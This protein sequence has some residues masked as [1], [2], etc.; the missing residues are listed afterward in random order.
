MR[1]MATIDLGRCSGCLGCVEIAPEV[2]HFNPDTGLIEVIE[3][4]ADA[5]QLVDEAICFCPED[6]ICWEE[7]V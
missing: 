2:F 5:E 1:R 6:C 7:K 4:F 3:G